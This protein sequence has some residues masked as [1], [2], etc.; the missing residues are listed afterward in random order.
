[1]GSRGASHEITGSYRRVYTLTKETEQPA[2]RLANNELGTSEL[3]FSPKFIWLLPLVAGAL[4]LGCGNNSSTTNT[5]KDEKKAMASTEAKGSSS[6]LKQNR[7]NEDASRSSNTKV[8]AREPSQKSEKSNSPSKTSRAIAPES[9]K[10]SSIPPVSAGRDSLIESKQAQLNAVSGKK[11]KALIQQIYDE[12][13]DRL[14]LLEE[15][16]R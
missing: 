9:Q 10:R 6:E 1:M 2:R 16:G 14:S 11:A 7:Q 8:T 5:E 12:I 13:E 3:M 4:L 15:Q